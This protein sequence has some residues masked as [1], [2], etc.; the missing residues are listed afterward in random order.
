MQLSSSATLLQLPLAQRR[1]ATLQS[2]VTLQ[3]LVTV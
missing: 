3:L 2:L 1:W